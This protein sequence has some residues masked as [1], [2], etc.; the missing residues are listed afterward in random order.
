MKQLFRSFFG[1]SK[2]EVNG[3]I[4]LVIIFLLTMAYPTLHR[5][6]SSGAEP[7]SN[8]D[9]RILDSLVAVLEQ[10][11]SIE[12]IEPQQFQFNP[13]TASETELLS[14]GFSERTTK[15]II[16]YRAKGGKFRLKKDLYRIY[17]I[18][19]ALVT[20]LYKFINLPEEIVSVAE[21]EANREIEEKH[22]SISLRPSVEESIERFD[23]N[24]AD[25]AMLQTINGI[26]SVLSARIVSFRDKLGGFI[27]TDQLNEVYNLDSSVVE[28]LL[29][30]AYID[31]LTS[32]RFLEINIIDEENLANHPYLNYKQS[33]L[34]IAYRNQHGVFTSEEEL[35]QV[36]LVN[37]ADIERLR[38]YLK[39]D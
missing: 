34:I 8:A 29:D 19:S 25:T 17:S 21:V 1:A 11:D 18:D 24:L 2:K 37:Q 36:Y 10:A 32:I 35:L 16:N 27:S 39:F 6:F 30:V 5:Y 28:S 3:I 4:V 13:N 26:G 7:V 33:R 12:E 38:P 22:N 14:L 20:S 31:S 23:L 9:A 15:Q